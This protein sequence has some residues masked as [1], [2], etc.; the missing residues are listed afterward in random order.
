MGSLKWIVWVGRV[1]EMGVDVK[2]ESKKEKAV[3]TMPC[4]YKIVRKCVCVCVSV[5]VCV[6][7]CQGE[8]RMPAKTVSVE[9]GYLRVVGLQIIFS[10]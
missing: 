10:F 2:G 4:S 9:G 5:Y 8:Q 3:A 6:S 7:V 1:G